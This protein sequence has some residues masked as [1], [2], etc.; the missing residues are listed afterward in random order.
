[1]EGNVTVIDPIEKIEKAMLDAPPCGIDIP[2]THH[3]AEVDQVYMREC[4]IPAGS[5]VL[6]HRHK[7]RHYNILLS[8]R[9]RILMDGKVQEM[10]GPGKIFVS[11]AGIR[12]LAFFPE[13][14][15]VLNIHCAATTNLDELEALLIEKSDTF[16]EHALQQEAILLKE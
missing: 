10:T 12:K 13:D 15:R 7:T 6:G 14:S 16:K 9:M 2:I 11:E 5:F 1:M 8:G 3:L 4:A